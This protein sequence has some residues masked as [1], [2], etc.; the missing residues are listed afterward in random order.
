[1]T[2]GQRIQALRKGRGLSQEALGEALGISRQAVSKWEGDV[3]T[4]ELEKL[5]ALSCLFEVP[6][7]ELL[8]VE[9]REKQAA[10]PIPGAGENRRMV[11]VLTMLCAVLA[12]TSILSLGCMI[13]F[14]YQVM[15][16][17]D[18]PTPPDNPVT[19]V[20]YDLESNEKAGTLDLALELT[21]EKE[22]ALMGWDAAAVLSTTVWRDKENRHVEE[23]APVT[24][25]DGRA[26]VRLQ[27]APYTPYRD[28]T[29]RLSFSKGDLSAAQYLLKIRFQPLE[30]GWE[31]TG[32][33]RIS[34]EENE[35]LLPG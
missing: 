14:R 22:T 31:I 16:V 1:M 34:P 26:W 25:S 4:P 6:V 7:G 17:L 20:A 27:A 35:N 9:E 30:G 23:A 24:F 3:T 32:R 21:L 12:V 8:G 33:G 10:T 19:G 5:V 13:Y 28:I 29:V 15:T 2:L 18:P 11:R